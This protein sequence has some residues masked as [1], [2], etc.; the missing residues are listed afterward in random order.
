MLEVVISSIPYVHTLA[1][2]VTTLLPAADAGFGTTT[3]TASRLAAFLCLKKAFLSANH[4]AS[5]TFLFSAVIGSKFAGGDSMPDV[6][7]A[8]IAAGDSTILM[9]APMIASK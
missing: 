4:P 6:M 8:T 7:A 5:G 1:T 3:L 2:Q 9:L